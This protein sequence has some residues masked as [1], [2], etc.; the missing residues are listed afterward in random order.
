MAILRPVCSGPQSD[1]TTPVS[2]VNWLRLA[3]SRESGVDSFAGG[4]RTFGLAQ[5][6]HGEAVL[7]GIVKL[8]DVPLPGL[9]I[10]LETA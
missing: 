7:G 6:K 5:G 10:G 2:T 4:E 3:C 8:F 1:N 9:R